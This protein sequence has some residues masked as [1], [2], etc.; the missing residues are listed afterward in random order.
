MTTFVNT[1]RSLRAT[2]ILLVTIGI[3]LCSTIGSAQPN[4]AV[5]DSIAKVWTYPVLPQ[6]QTQI[7][8]LTCGP[9]NELYSIYGHTAIRVVNRR[10]GIDEVYN[11][12][13]FDFETP[14]FAW[15]FAR[16]KLPYYVIRQTFDQF[17]YEYEVTQRSV[18]EQVMNLSPKDVKD[19]QDFLLNNIRPENKYYRY[20]FLFDNCST[21]IRD[22]FERILGNRYQAGTA[23]GT[24]PVSFRKILN[25]YER[26]LHWERF[27]I[28]LLMSDRVDDRMTNRESFFLPDYYMRGLATATVDGRLLVGET[29][30]LLSEQNQY[31]NTPN[32]QPR[33]VFWVLLLGVLL[34][35]WLPGKSGW[36]YYFDVLLFLVI[37][38][39]GIFMLLMW[40]GTNHAVC[41]WNRNLLWAMPLHVGFAWLLAKRSEKAGYYARYANALL[42]ASFFYGFVAEQ[43]YIVEITPI[44]LLL[45]FRL[46]AASKVTRWINFKSNLGGRFGRS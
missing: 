36:L 19:I 22:I 40:F 34:L 11:Y 46:N 27:G 29:R 12:G 6:D 18:T 42:I 44:L 33:L 20:D 38:L 35:S 41:A 14:F 37:G 5:A 7:S 30:T 3:L 15:K 9:G 32:N 16:G 26:N 39:L 24:E 8:I 17:M 43:E 45:F 25:Q 31:R 13:T 28:N 4:H 21:R 23:L 10:E 2:V 1:L